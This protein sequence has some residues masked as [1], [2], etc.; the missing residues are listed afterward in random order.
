MHRNS[1]RNWRIFGNFSSCVELISFVIRFL[2]FSAPVCPTTVLFVQVKRIFL[3]FLDSRLLKAYNMKKFLLSDI[4]RNGRI[5]VNYFRE[6]IN[7]YFIF[8][9]VEDKDI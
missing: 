5:Q 1:V 3:E 8:Q 2:S 6:G 4:D 7:I 9:S